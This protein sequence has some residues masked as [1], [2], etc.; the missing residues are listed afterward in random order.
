MSRLLRTN[1]LGQFTDRALAVLQRQQQPQS[2][3]IGQ[4]LKA[5]ADVSQHHIVWCIH[6][7]IVYANIPMQEYESP[8]EDLISVLMD[9]VYERF[10][11]RDD[12]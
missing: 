2:R 3:R 8:T 1:D 11:L 10:L 5:R 7:C 6:E 4:R 12:V 9:P